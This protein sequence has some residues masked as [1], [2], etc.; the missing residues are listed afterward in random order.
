M[1]VKVLSQVCGRT[2]R[3]F[4]LVLILALGL[5][6]EASAQTKA[7]PQGRDEIVLSFAPVV[8]KA[9][10]AVVNIFT[11]KEV[12][13]PGF[14]SPLFE[15][16]LF[17]RFFGENFGGAPRRRLERSLGSGVIVDSGGL[18]VTNHHVIEGAS[19]ITVVLSDRREFEALVVV[20]DART[21]LALLSIDP[22]GEVL[23]TLELK[24]SDDV[25]VGDLVLALGNP[26]GV[27]QTVTS[28]IVSALGRTQVDITDFSSF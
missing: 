17:K 18:V 5:I 15:D 6:P 16:P 26:F 7:L 28:G 24:N 4:G 19:E 9:A 23:P 13:Q 27:G 10:P 1:V 8:K 2:A 12:V 25:E 21:D 11:K 14:V 22:G 3:F 20:S